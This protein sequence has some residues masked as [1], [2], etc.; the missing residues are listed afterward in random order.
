MPDIRTRQ[1]WI[2][3]RATPRSAAPSRASPLCASFSEAGRPHGR[4]QARR[5]AATAASQ[6][7]IQGVDLCAVGQLLGHQRRCSPPDTQ[8]QCCW[9]L[10][11]VVSSR[12]AKFPKAMLSPAVF[13]STK[14]HFC[15][16]SPALPAHVSVPFARGRFPRRRA[17]R[18]ASMRTREESHT[19]SPPS[20]PP[21]PVPA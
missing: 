5:N 16:A 1:S 17:R 18:F 4:G 21:P 15:R 13:G 8:W 7:V 12:S 20:D 6:L 2:S 10:P 9:L 3:T 11:P 19:N 14:R